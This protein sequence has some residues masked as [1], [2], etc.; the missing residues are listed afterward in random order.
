MDFR[1]TE[2]QE[3]MIESLRELIKREDLE[4]YW[5]ECDRREENPVKVRKVLAENGL[6]LLGL[7]EEEGE[8]KLDRVTFLLAAEELARHGIMACLCM[9]LLKVDTILQFGSAEQKKF[10][11][12]CS[13]QGIL[14]YGLGI[15]EPQ[16]GSDNNMMT[17]TATRKDGKVY[18]NGHKS[19]CSEAKDVQYIAVFTKNPETDKISM[20]WVPTNAPGVQ[21][22][23]LRKIGWRTESFCEVYLDNVE[24]EE[25]NLV[26]VEGNGFI[27]LMKNFETERLL[28]AATAMGLATCAFEDAAR[29][30]NQRVQF[31]TKIGSF[32]LIQEKIV[33][34]Q[35]KIEH[36]RNL[37]YKT[38]WEKDNGISVQTSSALAKLYCCQAAC[39]VADDAM[40]ILGGLGYTED[41]RVAR[42]WR[43]LRGFRFGGGTDEIMIHI[44]GR[45]IL[46]AY[47]K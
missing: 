25:T 13:N 31:G 21:L 5:A 38:A 7:A 8:Y 27:Q 43:D 24:I 16:A 46:K 19:F 45:Q 33:Y 35:L 6:N 41:H 20:W 29:Y 37:V 42:I 47:S 12:D 3:L 10:V 22:E 28:M 36:M 14:S 44:A 39:E 2:E 18:I 9:D 26:G 1:K 40:Q 30:A 11:L 34:M 17:A 4:S 32:Q 23:E 15:T